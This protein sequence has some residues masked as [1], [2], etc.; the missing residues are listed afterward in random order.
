MEMAIVEKLAGNKIFKPSSSIFDAQPSFKTNSA[1][2][3]RIPL[4]G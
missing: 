3:F 2:K 4:I 1:Q